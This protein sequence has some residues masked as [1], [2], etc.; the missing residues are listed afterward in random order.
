MS[1][2]AKQILRVVLKEGRES[3]SSHCENV[4]EVL[5]GRKEVI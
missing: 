5:G 2:V 1:R 3:M 4:K